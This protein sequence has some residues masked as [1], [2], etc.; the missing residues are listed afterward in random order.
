MV[1]WYEGLVFDLLGQ[2]FGDVF[3]FEMGDFAELWEGGAGFDVVGEGDVADCVE[4]GVGLALEVL[5]DDDLPFFTSISAD[6]AVSNSGK[7]RGPGGEMA[8]DGVPII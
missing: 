2:I 6:I 4:V 3:P 8:F 5:V 7:S 1:E